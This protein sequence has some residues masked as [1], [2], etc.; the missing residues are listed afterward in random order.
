M[1]EAARP[2]QK[3]DREG[4]AV[5]ARAAVNF[6]VCFLIAK[7][8][9]APLFALPAHPPGPRWRGVCYVCIYKK[10]LID[11]DDDDDDDENN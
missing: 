11:E 10:K 7:E 8:A 4:T 6:F 2:L 5:V 3:A 9:R 1:T